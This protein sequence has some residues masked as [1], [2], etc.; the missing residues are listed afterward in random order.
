[1]DQREQ[2]PGDSGWPDPDAG[3]PWLEEA[4]MWTVAS[5][6]ISVPVMFGGISWALDRWLRTT[7]FVPFG[8]LAGMAVWLYPVRVRYGTQQ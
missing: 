3:H 6:L 1:M 7:F 5:Y 2:P 8:I 4:R